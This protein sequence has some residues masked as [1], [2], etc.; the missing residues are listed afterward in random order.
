M[1]LK[2]VSDSPD[3]R[4]VLAPKV[5]DQFQDNAFEVSPSSSSWH[6]PQDRPIRRDTRC[7]GKERE[8]VR[9]SGLRTLVLKNHLSTGLIVSF[10]YVGE[11]VEKGEQVR[12]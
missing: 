3:S 7:W 5:E 8:A 12:E 9:Q 2:S 11:R 4:C 1:L 6:S 10:L